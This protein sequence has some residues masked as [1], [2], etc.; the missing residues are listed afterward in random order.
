[1]LGYLFRKALG[2]LK[3]KAK[4]RKKPASKSQKTWRWDLNDPEERKAFL[5]L[6]EKIIEQGGGICPRCGNVIRVEYWEISSALAF[7]D[8][9]G[10]RCLYIALDRDIRERE[11][12]AQLEK[13]T[14]QALWI[15]PTSLANVLDQPLKGVLGHGTKDP[16][17]ERLKA[18]QDPEEIR[19]IIQQALDR[20]GMSPKFISPT[21]RG[22]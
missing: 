9:D 22:P 7:K 13:E 21:I 5:Q 10:C 6:V 3:P 14:R 18:L 11:K 2:I 15:V 12:H 17:Q 16:E 1:M 19:R 4:E 8:P 20:P